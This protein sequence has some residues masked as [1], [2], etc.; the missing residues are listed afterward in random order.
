VKKEKAVMK[1]VIG[2]VVE[3]VGRVLWAIAGIGTVFAGA[4]YFLTHLTAT[5]IS[6]PQEAALAAGSLVL[7]IVPYVFARAFDETVVGRRKL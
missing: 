2:V 6:A 1:T 7:A 5:E 4:N 3:I